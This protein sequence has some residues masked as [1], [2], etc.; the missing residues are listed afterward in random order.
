MGKKK[1]GKVMKQDINVCCPYFHVIP[2]G[3]TNEHKHLG[4]CAKG[5]MIS[6]SETIFKCISDH[7]W[8][9]CEFFQEAEL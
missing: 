8:N 1:G 6:N 5:D 3:D 4:C 2:C 7:N 9:A